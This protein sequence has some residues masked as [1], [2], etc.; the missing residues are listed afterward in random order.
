[1]PER[2]GLEELQIDWLVLADYAEVL[3]NKL[4]L[5][6]GGWD[7]LTVDCLPCPKSI[8]IALAVRVPWGMANERHSFEIDITFE[9]VSILKGSGQFEVQR[10]VSARVGRPLRM[11]VCST[12]VVTIQK[13]GE[14][15]VRARVDGAQKAYPFYVTATSNAQ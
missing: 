13:M 4:Y 15:E 12:S 9:D 11:Q 14:Y 2:N 8:A 5:Q 3:N 7:R 1:M 10:P 6:G